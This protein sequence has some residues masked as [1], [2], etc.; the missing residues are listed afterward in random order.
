MTFSF[1][2]ILALPRTAT[3]GYILQLKMCCFVENFFLHAI[4]IK[5]S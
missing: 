1:S 5:T 2:E 4:I 3:L